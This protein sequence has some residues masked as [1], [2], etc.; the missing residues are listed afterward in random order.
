MKKNFMGFNW[1]RVYALILG[2][3]LFLL[4][5]LILAQ[6]KYW[7]ATAGS[8]NGVGGSATWGTTFSTI[9]TGSTSLTTAASTD[10]VAFQGT[11]GTVTLSGAQTVASLA[12]NVTG[13]TLTTSNSTA[14]TLTGGITLGNNV[15][16]NIS[17][18]LNGGL[19]IGSITGGT[20]SA[21]NIGGTNA[22]AADVTRVNLLGGAT[23]A[24][25]API[26]I[27]TSGNIGI[28]GIVS[29]TATSTINSSITNNTGVLTMLGATSGNTLNVGGVV[30][31]SSGVRFSGGS[32][33][34]AGTVNLNV[35]S[36]YTGVTQFNGTNSGV[37]K[38]GVN[39]GLSTSSNVIMG[40][41]SGNGQPFDL[42]GFDQTLSS[43]SSNTGGTGSITNNASGT[44]TNTLTINGSSSTTFGLII[45]DGSTRKT[46]VTRSG[47]GTTT[48]SGT[49]TYTG[50]T[51]VNG[52]TFQM[53]SA[54]AL[55]STGALN[56]GG[57]TFDIFGYGASVGAVTLGSGSIINSDNAFPNVTLTA[58]SFDVQ[59]GTCSAKLAGT[60][61]A[62]TKST[63]GIVTLSGVNTYTGIT[64]IN[65]GTLSVG[66][67]GNGGVAGNLGQA[68]NAAA[69]LVL[70]GGTLLY[71]SSTASTDRNFTLTAATTSTIDVSTGA[72][73][74]TISG[75]SA[76]TTGALTKAGLGTLILTGGNLHTGL[77]TVSAGTLKLNKTGGT[78]IPVGNSATVTGG[79]LQISTNQTLANLTVNGGAVTVDDGVTLTI[80][81]TLTL[82]SGKITLGTG[83]IVA[84]A[85]S[86]GS[87][88]SYVVTT[89]TGKLT[90]KAVGAATFPIGPTASA[91]NPVS[92]SNGGNVDYAV[93][94][95]TTAP[96]GTGI[97][98][99]TAVINRQWDITPTGTPVNVGLTFQYNALEGASAFAYTGSLDGI[100]FNGASW[101]YIGGGTGTGVGPYMVSFAYAGGAGWSPFSFG[102]AGVLPTE[103][104]ALKATAQKG[105]NL[106]TWQTVTEKN[107]SHF[108]VQ[109]TSNPQATWQKIGTIKAAGN[110]QT[111]QTY[112]Y[113]DDT[114]LSISYYRL[115]SVDFDGKETLSNTVS[116]NFSGK[117]TDIKVFPTHSENR[118]TVLGN[119]DLST[120]FEVANLLGQVV[121]RDRFNG[122]NDI[123]VH[124]LTTGVYIL[125]VNNQTAKFFKK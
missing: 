19:T 90:I 41:S 17:P 119:I 80:T 59:S 52:G 110:S 13:Y 45:A 95:S 89:G 21:V 111:V 30:S 28:A 76:N 102:N 99:P 5:R 24:S 7:D 74:L 16:L 78:T 23:I 112:Q 68:T 79:T 72:T 123:D 91:Y 14:R 86:G 12:F 105:Q 63:S 96:S 94:V 124:A 82:T 97:S 75:A 69:N 22:A 25:S 51:N 55:P 92:I 53:G 81:G 8:G 43:L 31:G 114:P 121:L 48:F 6:D 62:L 67:I 49:N 87:S 84:A 77:T 15:T 35:A 9:S 116:V 61:V 34:G 109:R 18:F 20:S 50:G 83:N 107:S 56:I 73:S 122:S 42:N 54:T 103:L 85:I 66:T 3:G 57:G 64:T 32:S 46:A 39:N 113:S 37:V 10:A 4:P 29:G 58:T 47:S 101:G 26:T 11:A 108:E 2:L 44:S 100:H 115:R 70:G 27:S 60:N 36:T 33:G 117:T 118:L 93:N 65:A 1:V 125:N 120:T 104:S 40:F 38:L 106:L 71:S 88:S 98:Q